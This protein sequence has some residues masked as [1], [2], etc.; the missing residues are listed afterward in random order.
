QAAR[1]RRALEHHRG[2]RR[3]RRSADARAARLGVRGRPPRAVAAEPRRGL[4]RRGRRAPGGCGGRDG[5]R[6]DM[7]VYANGREVSGKATPNK[8]IAAFPDVC[9]SPPSPPAGPIP[10][11]YPNFGM[12]SDTTDGCSSVFVKGKEAGKK[13]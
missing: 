6:P 5:G 13:N 10:I 11:P 8:T 2:A 12:A 1:L 7:S 4:C 9:M 3:D